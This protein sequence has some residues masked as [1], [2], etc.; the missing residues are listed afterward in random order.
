MKWMVL[1]LTVLTSIAIADTSPSPSPSPSPGP[2]KI[3]VLEIDTGVDQ[4]NLNISPYLNKDHIEKNRTDYID[5]HGHGTHIAGLIIKDTCSEVELYSCK[6][7]KLKD[8][9]PNGNINRE[10]NCFNIASTM[11]LDMVV[12]AGGGTD[13]ND[14][15]KA[16]IQKLDTAGVVVVVAAG[17][18]HT[19]L[20]KHPYYPASYAFPNMVV[21]GN[22]DDN[23]KKIA[24]SSDY[25]FHRMAFKV[26]MGVDSTLPGNTHGRMTGTSQATAEM[27][28][29]ML[30]FRCE[31][32]K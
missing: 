32:V 15:E 18:E 9:V 2:N 1:L 14:D 13:P 10:I 11:G 26:G 31:S 12:Y 22:L 5:D 17:N 24:Q 16:A 19:N 29:A 3:K 21:V 7:F 25:N 8:N 6:Y 28:N 20:H 27:A 30:K 4:F 23:T